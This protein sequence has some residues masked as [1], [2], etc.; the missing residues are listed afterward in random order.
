MF[1]IRTVSARDGAVCAQFREPLFGELC[2]DKEETF[3]RFAFASKYACKI[4]AFPVRF[5]C[6]QNGNDHFRR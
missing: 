5:G 3:R 6:S 2:A 1:T 4:T